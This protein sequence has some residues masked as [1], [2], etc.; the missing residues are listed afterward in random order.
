MLL[1]PL[2]QKELTE[3][4]VVFLLVCMVAH[5]VDSS[6]FFHEVVQELIRFSTDKNDYYRDWYEG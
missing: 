4:I 1:V 2:K 5:W 3:D 6:D